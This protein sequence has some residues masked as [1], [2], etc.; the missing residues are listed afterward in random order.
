[1]IWLVF[2]YLI[3]LLLSEQVS[4]GSVDALSGVL[5]LLVVAPRIYRGL[6]RKV[7]DGFACERGE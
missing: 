6:M 7:G 1:M 4:F 2:F 5:V 3:F